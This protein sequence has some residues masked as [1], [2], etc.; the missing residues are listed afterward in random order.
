M[1]LQSYKEL[2]V[3]QKSIT[4]VRE[5]YSITDS[6][7][8]SEIYGLVSQLRRASISI[9]S[10]IAEGHARKSSKEFSHALSIAYGSGLEVETQLIIAKELGFIN[11]INFNR[12]V[13]RLEEVLRMLNKMTSSRKE[14]DASL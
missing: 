11:E 14:L 9:P 6:F 3:W 10:N 4:L 7:P 1:Y 5:I 2:I 8:R 13:S 12:V